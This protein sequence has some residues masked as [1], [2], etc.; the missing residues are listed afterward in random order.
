[1]VG[2]SRSAEPF[3]AAVPF[4]AVNRP[5]HPGY[6]PGLQRHHLIPRELAQASAF[7]A[8]F[9]ALGPARTGLDDF[10]RNGLLLPATEQAAWRTRLPLHR[11]PHRQY[12]GLVRERIGAIERDW[13]GQAAARSGIAAR[14][15]QFRL[16]L[17]QRA[18][19][20]SLL[21][22]AAERAPLNRLDPASAAVLFRELDAMADQL[23]ADTAQLAGATLSR[24]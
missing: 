10:C 24:P 11:G 9:S 13:A 12:T 15:A 2:C 4:R 19:R 1:M 23:W 14:E 6:A 7:A 21:R 3:R 17:L 18:L 5:G 20:R 16:E 22:P 8:L